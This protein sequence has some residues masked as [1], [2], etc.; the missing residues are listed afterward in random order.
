MKIRI[1]INLAVL[2][3]IVAVHSSA[4][5][6][7]DKYSFDSII[8]NYSHEIVFK[9]LALN[10]SFKL[11]NSIDSAIA[12]YQ[13]CFE[14]FAKDRSNKY[15]VEK[16]LQNYKYNL[17]KKSYSEIARLEKF[18]YL[19]K[20]ISI[21]PIYVKENNEDIL[22][23]SLFENINGIDKIIH[24]KLGN[25]PYSSMANCEGFELYNDILIYISR[26]NNKKYTEIISIIFKK[27]SKLI[28][29]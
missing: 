21:M 29:G 22:P 16:S 7:Y 27:Y 14:E 9:Y 2:F 24:N 20:I 13:K 10:H 28:A 15:L 6:K 18:C 23:F 19:N 25:R 3:L 17:N 11:N 5:L 8:N 26:Q 1:K 12:N 4:Q